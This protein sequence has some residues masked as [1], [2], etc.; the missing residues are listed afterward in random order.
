MNIDTMF[1]EL[2][3][4]FTTSFVEKEN[5]INYHVK[6][7]VMKI[8]VPG[9]KKEDLKITL[10]NSILNITGETDDR[11]IKI[12]FNIG[13]RKIKSTKLDLGVLTIEFEDN[14]NVEEIKID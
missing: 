14:D 6:D 13:D 10:K 1:N 11:K 7:N 3:N 5:N 2:L 9:I 12:K 4:D 8:D